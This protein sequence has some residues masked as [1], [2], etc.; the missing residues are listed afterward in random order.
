MATELEAS[1]GP[2]AQS[3][4]CATATGSV[5][6]LPPLFSQLPLRFR[7]KPRILGAS[8][9]ASLPGQHQYQPAAGSRA[10]WAQR[11]RLWVGSDPGESKVWERS[12]AERVCLVLGTTLL[13]S[14]GPSKAGW[15]RLAGAQHVR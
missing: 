2:L 3:S 4:R 10:R 9:P 8:E 1:G 15:L 11:A 14:P 12:G 5:L 13:P 7:E 6:G